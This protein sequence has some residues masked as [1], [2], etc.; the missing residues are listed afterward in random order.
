MTQTL[1]YQAIFEAVP[2]LHLILAPDQDFTILAASDAQLRA[3]HTRRE[4]SIGRP[5]FDVFRKNPDDPTEFGT[6]VLRD[7]LERVLR[8]R[9]P[10]R[11]AITRYD[12]P[13]P[14]AQGGGFELRYWRPL[15]VPVLDE[16]GAVLYIIHQV[17]DVT[18]EV[19]RQDGA[20]LSHFEERFRAA[21]LGSGIGTFTWLFSD[22]SLSLD[23]ALEQLFRLPLGLKVAN[24]DAF[25]EQVHPQDRADVRL[26]FE[27]YARRR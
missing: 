27:H 17:E 10:D 18:E 2:N 24:V 16:H 8:S 3:T 22:G 26:A 9:T 5:V 12:I 15:N 20:S 19:L 1:N 4:E 25:V 7:S 13:R 23:S 14:A 6:S 21:L 11:M